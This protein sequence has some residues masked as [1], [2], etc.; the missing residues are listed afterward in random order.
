MSRLSAS[1]IHSFRHKETVFLFK[2]F[3]RYIDCFPPM[4]ELITMVGSNFIKWNIEK[5][6]C[7]NVAGR[8]SRVEVVGAGAGKGRGCG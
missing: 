6:V 2:L 4:S 8:D 5:G 1:T 7:L 3:K